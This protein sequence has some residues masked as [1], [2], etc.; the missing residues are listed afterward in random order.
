MHNDMCRWPIIYRS[1]TL[2]IT[3]VLAVWVCDK[4]QLLKGPRVSSANYSQRPVLVASTQRKVICYCSYSG[5]LTVRNTYLTSLEMTALPM[6]SR[7][8]PRAVLPTYLGSLQWPQLVSHLI[9]LVRDHQDSRGLFQKF[10]PT[11]RQ[12]R[13]CKA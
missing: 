5:A 9:I 11:S 2:S 3:A 8:N 4:V 6:C 7:R 1:R 12:K 13:Q 10:R